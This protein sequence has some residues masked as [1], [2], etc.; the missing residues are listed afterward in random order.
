MWRQCLCAIRCTVCSVWNWP[1]PQEEFNVIG[2]V[3]VY[4]QGFIHTWLCFKTCCIL[5]SAGQSVRHPYVLESSYRSNWKTSSA[6]ETI[7]LKERQQQIE[8]FYWLLLLLKQRWKIWTEQ[9][10]RLRIHWQTCGVPWIS[11]PP[12]AFSYHSNQSQKRAATAAGPL[13]AHDY[14]K[15]DLFDHLLHHL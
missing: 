2:N 5:H 6:T 10:L 3:Y 11:L 12:V 1:D 13:L 8:C 14:V 7:Y 15:R 4:K 9:D